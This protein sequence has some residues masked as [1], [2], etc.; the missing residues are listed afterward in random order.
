MIQVHF[1]SDCCILVLV[2]LLP[3]Y[4]RLSHVHSPI[5]LFHKFP[6]HYCSLL[7]SHEPRLLWSSYFII[8]IHCSYNF[9]VM[10]RFHWSNLRVSKDLRWIPMFFHRW[11]IPHSSHVSHKIP[12]SILPWWFMII[13]HCW[14]LHVWWW[15]ISRD[16]GICW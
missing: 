4:S 1:I 5:W 2:S 9:Q 3:I 6:S 12:M 7:L 13:I 16:R 10:N 11:K 8:I 15:S 14:I